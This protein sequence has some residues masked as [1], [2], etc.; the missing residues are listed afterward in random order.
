[1]EG[2]VI[3][4]GF[5]G[6]KPAPIE[7]DTVGETDAENMFYPGFIPQ[8]YIRPVPMSPV[9]PSVGSESVNNIDRGDY[10]HGVTDHDVQHKDQIDQTQDSNAIEPVVPESNQV[11]KTK[12]IPVTTRLRYEQ[13]RRK[14]RPSQAT[15][16]TSAGRI[17]GQFDQRDQ[18]LIQNNG[19][20]TIYI[21]D[22]NQVD[23]NTGFPLVAGASM[24]I[25]TQEA[26]YAIAASTAPVVQPIAMIEE[27]VVQ[28]DAYSG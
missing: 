25:Q 27:Y 18:I 1:M 10:D 26:V 8:G 19:T 23:S 15:V 20:V 12:P 21:G 17:A 28:E 9:D 5:W 22:D 16:G 24:T 3:S 11:A 14:F 6:S 13:E 7:V 4:V 2:S